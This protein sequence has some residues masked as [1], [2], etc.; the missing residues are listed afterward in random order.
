MTSIGPFDPFGSDVPVATT[1]SPLLPMSAPASCATTRLL[2]ARPHHARGREM[3]EWAWLGQE[4]QAAAVQTGSFAVPFFSV[5]EFAGPFSAHTQAARC[6][7]GRPDCGAPMT[8]LPALLPAT[9]DTEQQKDKKKCVVRVEALTSGVDSKKK[10]G[11]VQGLVQGQGWHGTPGRHPI[12]SDP[13]FK[14]TG[15]QGTSV[16]GQVPQGLLRHRLYTR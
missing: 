16:G 5:F 2:Q 1:A 6:G 10:M 8:H 3:S 9:T 13:F 14:P 7:R 4:R 15:A 11:Q 12:S